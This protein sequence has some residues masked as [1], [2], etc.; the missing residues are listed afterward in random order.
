MHLLD[1]YLHPL[2]EKLRTICNGTLD[3]VV[4]YAD[5]IS[6][7]IAD[8]R[9]LGAIQQAFIN[10]GR[11]SRLLLNHEKTIAVNIGSHRAGRGAPWPRVQESVKIWGI[12]FF[13]SQKQLID[14][15]WAKVIRK[16]FRLMW[17]YKSRNLTLYQKII[18][19]NTFITSRLWFLASVICYV[20][21]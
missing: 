7:V 12:T 11:C 13:H 2:L 1:L 15:N 14:Y 20:R 8:D 18:V 4:A 9:K 21:I 17:M 16:T 10:F 3:L 19:L 6:I 5:D